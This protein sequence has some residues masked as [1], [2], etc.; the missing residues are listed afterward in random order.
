MPHPFSPRAIHPRVPDPLP[1]P[2]M[3]GHALSLQP[4]EG[5]TLRLASGCL[6]ATFDGPHQGPAN[7]WGDRVLCAGEQL[8]VRAGQRLVIEPWRSDTPASFSW[9]PAVQA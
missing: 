5:G 6:W 9:H 3:P 1:A 2:L 8:T 7:D 4:E